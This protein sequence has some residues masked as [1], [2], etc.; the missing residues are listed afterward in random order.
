MPDTLTLDI[1]LSAVRGHAA[2]FRRIASLQ[3]AGGPGTKVFPPTYS[4]AVYATE[5]RR[6]KDVAEPVPCV[7]LDSVQSQANRMEEALQDAYDR[8]Q[9]DEAGLPL[10]EV[11][12]GPFAPGQNAEAPLQL[13]D[14]VGRISSLQ[15]PH[16]VADAILRDSLSKE[17]TPFRQTPEGKKLAEANT[18]NATPLFELCPTALLFGLWD[19]TGPKGGLG[20][21]FERAIVSEIVGIDAVYGVKTSSRIDPLG[22]RLQ[23]GPVY[24]AK[25][26]TGVGWT[27]DAAAARQKKGQPEVRG[28]DGKPSEVNHGNVTPSLSEKDRD[29]RPLAGGVTISHAEHSV[30]LSLAALRRLRFP[31]EGTPYDA[32][33]K[34]QHERDDAA[35]AVL[36]AMGLLASTLATAGG[37]DLR[38]RCLLWNQGEASP[39]S[40]LGE[41]GTTEWTPTVEDLFRLY[42]DAVAAARAAGLPW[43]TKAFELRP[44]DA[45]VQLVVKSQELAVAQGG[46]GS[47]DN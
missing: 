5:E 2:G 40:L 3:P 42:N 44:S 24:A 27:T 34:K 22:T 47:E 30:V 46:D 9:F 14:A 39:W 37:M 12:F 6:M 33:D 20:A 13:R 8:G 21:K 25:D 31:L 4:G 10:V 11:D 28:K 18:H 38:S 26:D 19:S 35:R 7:L 15:A 29:G 32:R 23:A 36:A 43:R 41:S 16:R 45:L 1:L 17:G